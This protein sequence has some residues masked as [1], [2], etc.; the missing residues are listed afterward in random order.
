MLN[1]EFKLKFRTV[2]E[3]HWIDCPFLAACTPASGSELRAHSDLLGSVRVGA[4]ALASIRVDIEVASCAL[5][6][7]R[8]RCEPISRMQAAICREIRA[9][10]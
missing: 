8:H 5:H 3:G 9:K 4:T 6:F 10:K 7:L 1:G 2:S